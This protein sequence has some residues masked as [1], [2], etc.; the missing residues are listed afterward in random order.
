M[1]FEGGGAKGMV[2]VGALQELQ[3]RGLAPARLLGT[4]AG[5]IMSTFLA[6][7]YT[8]EEM[9]EAL[10]EEQ[11]GQPVF[12][13]FLETPPPLSKAE[14]QDSAIRALLHAVDV[15]LIPD[16]IEEKL[17]DAIA[18]AMAGSRV[19]SRI[20]SFIERGGFFAA[21]QFLAWLKGKLNTGVYPLARGEHPKG[22]QRAFGEMT[23]KEF[24]K[25]VGADLSLVAA[26]TT[27]GQLLI[28]NHR[29][30]P[31]LPVVYGVRMSM[32]VPLLWHEVVWQAEWGSYRGRDITGNTIVDGGMLSNFPIELFLSSQP[33]VTA[34]MG[35]PSV[36]PGNV[37]GF[38]IDE[39]AE[40]PGAP[41]AAGGPGLDLEFGK[42]RT[43]QRIAG[44]INTM[45]QAHDKSVVDAYEHLVVRLPAKGYGTIEFGMSPARRQALVD[46]GRQATR[47]YFERVAAAP[48]GV[49][50]MGMPLAAA[51]PLEALEAQAQA[52]D[53]RALRILAE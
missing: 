38:M 42:L 32:S 34:V 30:A 48:P 53:R 8:I 35:E 2:F 39:G 15:R 1:V 24:N 4:S 33:P 25:A 3:A 11:N 22:S 9:E 51:S 10:K 19:T 21:D 47:A 17:D 7:G 50:A 44:L 6:A 12:M 28:L 37:L 40:V 20:F 14:I 13:G 18:A 43:V 26:D 5:S 29:T 27:A 46:A 52:V 45:M 16:L 36:E 49:L 31:D 23:L 41:P